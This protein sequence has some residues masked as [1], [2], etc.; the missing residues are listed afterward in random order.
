[1][2]GDG[3]KGDEGSSV[4]VGVLL[5]YWEGEDD[6]EVS[7][8]R[9]DAGETF[10]RGEAGRPASASGWEVSNDD[11]LPRDCASNGDA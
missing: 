6:D 1:M 9:A 8:G 10:G 4:F 5:W 2:D 3:D 11:G 7:R